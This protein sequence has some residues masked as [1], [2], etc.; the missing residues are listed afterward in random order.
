MILPMPPAAR[1]LAIVLS[2]APWSCIRTFEPDLPC[3]TRMAEHGASGVT[4]AP[5]PLT[6]PVMWGAVVG[7][8]TPVWRLLEDAGV[9]TGTFNW[10][11]TAPPGPV[12]GFM[13]AREMSPRIDRGHFHPPELYSLLRKRFG[14]WPAIPRARTTQEW[15]SVPQ[16]MEIRTDVLVELLQTRPWS[17]ALAQLPEVS[18]AQHRFWGQNDDTLR[19]VYAASD[20]AIGRIMDAV[21]PETIVFVFSQCGAGSVRYGIQLNAWLEQEGYLHRRRGGASGLS[22]SFARWYK[23]NAR[24]LVPAAIHEW[25]LKARV[26]GAVTASDIDWS[27]TRAYSPPSSGEIVLTGPADDLPSR[28]LALRDPE[29]RQVVEEVIARE[30]RLIVVWNDDAYMPTDDFTDRDS[31]FVTWRPESLDTPLTGAH[32]REGFLLV[33]GPGIGRADLGRVAVADLVPT[34]LEL[35]GV[36]A[37]E[38]LEGS[39][40]AHLITGS[41]SPA[42][43]A[44]LSPTSAC[45]PNRD[46]ASL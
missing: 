30:S 39:S 12:S 36:D 34:W 23:R 7:G 1:V 22:L 14:V 38:E 25:P 35:M 4:L 40:F 19:T 29:G 20:R 16:E 5:Q 9:A 2:E 24:W 17:F 6:A 43:L 15:T 32:R 46:A 18:F 21:G 41:A 26:R 8:D 37:P 31:V 11:L 10:R 28:L 44:R 13:I 45:A 42:D 27:R 3:L 33:S